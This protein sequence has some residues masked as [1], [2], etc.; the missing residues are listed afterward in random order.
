MT[1]AGIREIR[2]QYFRHIGAHLHT[3][4]GSMT[5]TDDIMADRRT[6]AVTVITGA[7][8]ATVIKGAPLPNAFSLSAATPNP[9]NPATIIAR[10]VP[11]PTHITLTVCWVKRQKGRWIRRSQK[12]VAK[13]YVTAPA[14]CMA[15]LQ[16]P[17]LRCLRSWRVPAGTRHGV[18]VFQEIPRPRS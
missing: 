11:E 6:N 2:F 14:P 4:A 1:G 3:G 15:N 9:F 12:V 5:L 17:L 8:T 13:R 18:T 10:E 16:R 7:A